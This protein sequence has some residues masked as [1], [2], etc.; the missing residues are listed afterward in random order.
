MIN[1]YGLKK[2]ITLFSKLEL[3]DLIYYIHAWVKS[4][5]PNILHFKEKNKSTYLVGLDCNGSN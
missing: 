4:L 1:K 5:M 2:E 3:I